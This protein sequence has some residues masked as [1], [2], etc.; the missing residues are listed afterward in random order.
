MIAIKTYRD[1]LDE[2]SKAIEGKDDWI[3]DSGCDAL[4]N[5]LFEGPF[6]ALANWQSPASSDEVALAAIAL[7]DF[8]KAVSDGSAVSD[9]MEAAAIGYWKTAGDSPSKPQAAA[10]A[11]PRV[12]LK[13]VTPDMFLT[14]PEAAAYL[15]ISPITLAAWR[16]A[17]R[18]PVYIKTGGRV[19]YRVAALLDYASKNERRGTRPDE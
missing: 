17:K 1:A 9:A 4:Y 2:Y 10:E 14:A 16:S 7:A 5:D 15:R 3:G 12:S 19:L 18:G 8:E 6:A 11:T 13:D